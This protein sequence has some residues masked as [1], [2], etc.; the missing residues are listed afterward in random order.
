MATK[1]TPQ[2]VAQA[3]K[4]PEGD[5][6]F[7]RALKALLNE[8]AKDVLDDEDPV[9][10]RAIV[11]L[12]IATYADTINDTAGAFLALAARDLDLVDDDDDDDDDSDED[13][14][15]GDSEEDEA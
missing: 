3:R 4:P 5:A 13:S 10:K 7:I 1:K 12:T 14:A 2:R 8:V 15:E 9:D 6:S 11:D